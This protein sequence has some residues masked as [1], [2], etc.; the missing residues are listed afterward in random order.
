MHTSLYLLALVLVAMSP[1]P[2]KK[3]S[4][5]A[6]CT[7]PY[8]QCGGR[9]MSKRGHVHPHHCGWCRYHWDL[10]HSELA[11]VLVTRTQTRQHREKHENLH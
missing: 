2:A 1:A 10:S 7:N 4:C 5:G 8:K 11:E 3:L 6:V 9:C